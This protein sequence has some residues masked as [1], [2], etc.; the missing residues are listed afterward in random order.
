MNYYKILF[1]NLLMIASLSCDSEGA[2][3]CFQTAGTSIE[4]TIE[5][6]P[7]TEIIVHE[8][9]SLY[10]SEGPAQSVVVKTGENLLPDVSLEV[11]G[12]TL[13]IRDTNNCNYF[14]DY[15]ITEVYVTSPNLT[16]IRNS[17]Q[18]TIRSIG[19]LSFN[20]LQL[21]CENNNSDYLNVGDFDLSLDNVNNLRITS[22]GNAVFNLDGS[23]NNFNIGLFAGDARVESKSLIAN[24]ITVYGKST[25]DVLIYPVQK[26]EIELF[27]VGD[28]ISYNEP[29]E[30][31][32]VTHYTGSLIFSE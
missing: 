5:L 7:F 18:F 26:L 29:A 19:T 23:A 15:D 9:V 22:N 30:I 16:K 11:S 12:E 13:E 17:S 6:S 28:V 4:Q 21:I 20:D 14:R 24:E 31:I 25:N 1:W 32:S 10:L 8:N 27:N 2:S 3:D